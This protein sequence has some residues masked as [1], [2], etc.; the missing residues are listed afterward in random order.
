MTFQRWDRGSWPLLM[1]RTRH[2]YIPHSNRKRSQGVN[3][4]L[5][6]NNLIEST[7]GKEHKFIVINGGEHEC[8]NEISSMLLALERSKSKPTSV[9]SLCH[10]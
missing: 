1:E 3:T 5:R 7:L 6:N 8:F 9:R 10:D 4:Y 2:Q